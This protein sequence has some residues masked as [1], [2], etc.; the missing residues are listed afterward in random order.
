MRIIRTELGVSELW[1]T[2]RHFYFK[3]PRTATI[4]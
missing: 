4:T 3:V 1:M 2:P